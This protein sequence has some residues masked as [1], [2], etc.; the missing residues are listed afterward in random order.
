MIFVHY[1]F[2]F[3]CSLFFIVVMYI[4]EFT[5]STIL[6]IQFIGIKYIH[7]VIVVTLNYYIIPSKKH[8]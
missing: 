2:C 7:I 1:S 8:K 6:S 4:T 5:F 3:G